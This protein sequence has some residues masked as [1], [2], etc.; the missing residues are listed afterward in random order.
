MVSFAK[1]VGFSED[2][3]G[4]K[5]WHCWGCSPPSDTEDEEEGEEPNPEDVT[6]FRKDIKKLMLFEEPSNNDFTMDNYAAILL[7]DRIFAISEHYN[8]PRMS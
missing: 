1:C 8:P 2:E 5:D 7:R 6:I 4:S 3:A